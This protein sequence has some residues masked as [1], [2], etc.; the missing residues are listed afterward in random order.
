MAVQGG[1]LAT[2]IANREEERLKNSLDKEGKAKPILIFL[3]AKLLAYTF[4][5]AL[6]G[7]FGSVFQLSIT[8]QIIL[9]IAVGIFMI[10]MA[11]NL[12]N[13]HPVFR[14][15]ALQPPK[16]IARLIRK[17]SRKGNYFSPVILGAFTV[18]IP[19]G[20]TQAMMALSI[21]SGNPVNGAAILFSFILGTSPVFFI[22]GYLATKL[23]EAISGKFIKVAAAVII[24]LAIFNINTAL[25]L[26]D[27]GISLNNIF[28]PSTNTVPAENKSVK[29]DITINIV[30]SGYDPDEI[31]VKHG[32]KINLTINNISRGGCQAAF[33]IPKLNIQKI[34]YPGDKKTVEFTAPGTPQEISFMCSMGMYRGKIVV[35]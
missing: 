27:S 2:T 35:I 1:L 11:L 34:V 31:V 13:V 20:T 28:Q 15:F 6:L 4:L 24:I 9:Q 33:T 19:C 30:Q 16:F 10:G 5:G 8:T 32:E 3:L 17:E 7:L 14:Y 12:L 22:L 29:N 26:T 23:G 25:A 21:A 18:F